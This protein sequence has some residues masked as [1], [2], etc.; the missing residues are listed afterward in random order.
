MHQLRQP[1]IQAEGG[2]ERCL[3]LLAGAIL[4]TGLSQAQ[5]ICIDP[6]HPSENG[7]GTQGKK[8]TEVGVAWKVGLRLKKILEADGYTV[9]MTKSAERQKVTNARRA[10]IANKAH[11][12]FMIRLHCDAGHGSGLA[13]YYPGEVGSVG[14]S[15]GP[16]KEVISESRAAGEKFHPAVMKVL[17]GSLPDAGLHT[18]RKTKIGGKQGALTGSILSHVPVVLV[19]MCVLGNPKDEAFIATEA[20]K[21]K[22]ARALAAGVE[23]VVSKNRRSR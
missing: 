8:E 18:D 14:R 3:G 12:D 2:I 19:E 13:S 11:S 20:G 15:R 17:K 16:S 6:G 10:E 21:D 23:A 22:M 7:I 5:T 4:L 9:V 1:R